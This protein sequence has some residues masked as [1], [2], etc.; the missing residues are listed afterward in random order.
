[1]KKSLVVFIIVSLFLFLFTLIVFLLQRQG[2][3]LPSDSYLY[4]RLMGDIP[5]TPP[6]GFPPF[7]GISIREIYR[8]LEKA[9][10]DPKIRGIYLKVS[11][12]AIG[13]GKAEEIRN[14]ISAFKK[15]GKRVIAFVE[16][17]DD[18]GYYIA[19]VGDRV[20]TFPG[21]FVEINGIAAQRL[22]YKRL[23]EK[24]GISA[25]I[26]HIGNW[27]TAYNSY[28]E[29]KMTRW[30]REQLI[31][32]GNGIMEELKTTISSSR[33]IPP[34]KLQSFM[35]E[36]GGG[37]GVEFA[38]SKFFDGIAEEGDVVK[39]EF[40]GLHRVSTKKYA[41]MSSAVFSP[42]RIAVVFAEGVINMGRSGNFPFT[43]RVI[44]SD[45]LRGILKKLGREKRVKAVVLRINSPGGSALAS[46]EIENAVRK[47]AGKKPVVVSMSSYAASGGY[48]ISCPARKIIA[49]KLTLTGS[50]GIIGGKLSIGKALSKLG[51][52]ED[53]IAFSKTSLINSPYSEYDE[54]QFNTIKKRL[55]S[56]YRLFLKRVSQGRGKTAEEVD[57]LGQ[58]K[59]YLGKEAVKLGLVDATGGLNE[60]VEEA[61][62][63][64]GI[65]YYSVEFYPKRKSLWERIMSMLNQWG[66]ISRLKLFL[67]QGFYYL[68]ASFYIF[69]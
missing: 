8:A 7:P 54:H 30:E 62:R 66:A 51:I 17:A 42:N 27:K 1:M 41:S 55:T 32:L 36:E 52:D 47:L 59:V 24:W 43:G 3:T 16:G 64:A 26:F 11:F 49:E 50:I 67:S 10:S 45:T 6:Q 69:K 34:E 4:L 48:Y 21:S 56:F 28:T 61:S 63:L 38:N 9:K 35:D 18:L 14:L 12:P 29:R 33:G 15:T 65:S 60:A 2:K 39:K 57:K 46:E 68:P 23:F 20:Y 40:S 53:H 5:E 31:R 13:W 19:S 25:Q 37:I 44:G 58:G 22:Y